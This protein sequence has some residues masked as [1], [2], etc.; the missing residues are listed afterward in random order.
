MASPSEEEIES[1]ADR[2]IADGTLTDKELDEVWHRSEG[3]IRAVAEAARVKATRALAEA[4]IR[5]LE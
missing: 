5:L 2:A 3:D 4:S 1:V